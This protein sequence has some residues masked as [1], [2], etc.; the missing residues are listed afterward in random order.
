MALIEAHITKVEKEID[1]EWGTVYTD[2]DT[3]KKLTTKRPDLLS[4][5]AQLKVS[6]ALAGIDYAEKITTKQ[7]PEGP[8]TFHDYYFNGAGALGNGASTADDGIDVVKPTQQ[9]SSYREDPEKDW[10]ICLQTGAKLALESMPHMKEDQRSFE[11]Q[12]AVARAWAEF[13]IFT[14][15]PERWSSVPPIPRGAYDEP[16]GIEQPPPPDDPFPF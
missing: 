5:A 8:R 14:P 15:R 6:G 12:K 3:I 7:Y 11:H 4:E 13:F 9:G 10:R 2:H 16:E 1:S